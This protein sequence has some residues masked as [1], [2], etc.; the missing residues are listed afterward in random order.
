MDDKDGKEKKDDDTQEKDN[1]IGKKDDDTQEKEDDSN[2]IDASG[3]QEKDSDTSPAG[4]KKQDKKKSKKEK[5]EEE[6]YYVV[7][8]YGVQR[9][10]F[11]RIVFPAKV[12]IRDLVYHFERVVPLFF[13]SNGDDYV[14]GIPYQSLS[15]IT[16][17]Y[18]FMIIEILNG[19]RSLDILK[20]SVPQWI[21]N[22]I[23]AKKRKL[24]ICIDKFLPPKYEK[25]HS[26]KHGDEKVWVQVVVEDNGAIRVLSYVFEYDGFTW[27]LTDFILT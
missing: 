16:G 13:K 27:R 4:D 8:K 6:E 5:E 9:D 15:K 2:K 24:N 1:D 23:K 10:K 7:D 12:S 14:Q 19:M 18:T 17:A 22:Y 26:R 20:Y 3:K 21:E 11:N 25:I